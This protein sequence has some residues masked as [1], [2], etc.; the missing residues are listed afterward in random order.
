M[1]N[2]LD[3][4]GLMCLAEKRAKRECDLLF[5]DTPEYKERREKEERRFTWREYSH[6]IGTHPRYAV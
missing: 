3:Y 1:S 6:L 5:P 2:S 4:K